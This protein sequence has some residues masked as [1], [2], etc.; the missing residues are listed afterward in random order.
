[1]IPECLLSFPGISAHLARNGCS[2][3]PEPVLT[4][5]GMPAHIGSERLLALSPESVLSLPRNTQPA[6]RTYRRTRI[7]ARARWDEKA[8]LLAQSENRLQGTRAFE[9]PERRSAVTKDST[10]T[11]RKGI[12]A[13][14][15]NERET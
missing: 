10:K 1:M 15:K 7:P 2:P 12:A 14:G 5:P 13:K 9:S 3:C 11:T 6:S 8:D 4:I